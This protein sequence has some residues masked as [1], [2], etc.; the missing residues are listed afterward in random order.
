MLS[1]NQCTL[2]GTLAD[3]PNVTFSDAGKQST[4]FTMLLTEERDG[5]TFKTFVQCAAWGK[6][7]EVISDLDKEDELLVEGKISWKAGQ[8]G[9]PYVGWRL[10]LARARSWEMVGRTQFSFCT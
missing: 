7:A 9:K 1:L 8:D 4:T 2:A 6:A 5:Q 3:N 10:A